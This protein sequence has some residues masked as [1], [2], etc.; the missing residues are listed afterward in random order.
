MSKQPL[1]ALT[2]STEGPC[3]TLIQIS[4]TPGHR[5]FAQHHRTSRP[6]PG[7]AMVLSK[8]PVLGRPTNLDKSMT[9]AYCSGS[10]GWSGLVG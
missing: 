7:G 4:R 2:A 9:R 10:R 8:L 3:P 1:P 6:P 5:K